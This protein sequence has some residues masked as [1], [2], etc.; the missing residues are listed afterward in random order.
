MKLQ[1]FATVGNWTKL[2]ELYCG[3][4]IAIKSGGNLASVR[5][6]SREERENSAKVSV[7]FESPIPPDDT[8]FDKIFFFS[9]SI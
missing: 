1:L 8:E 5:A 4:K 2:I 6:R 3:N 9:F 7:Q